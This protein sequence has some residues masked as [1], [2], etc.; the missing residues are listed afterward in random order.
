MFNME[1]A[2]RKLPETLLEK[3]EKLAEREL[4]ML[5]RWLD[6]GELPLAKELILRRLVI[7]MRAAY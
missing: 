7:Q 4:K 2:V 6:E 5:S 1:R 3:A